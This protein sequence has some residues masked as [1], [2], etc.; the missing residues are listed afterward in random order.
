ME[1]AKGSISN[2]LKQGLVDALQ[3]SF[4]DADTVAIVDAKQRADTVLPMIAVDVASATNHS[5]ALREVQ[6]VNLTVTLVCHYADDEP[7]QIQEWIDELEV[8]LAQGKDMQELATNGIRIFDWVYVGS[9]EEWDE[10]SHTTN[11]TVATICTR[12]LTPLQ[13]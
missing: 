10:E 12:F 2:R 1:T 13:D 6:R 7:S 5:S 9:V 8:I 3:G 4:S 11:F